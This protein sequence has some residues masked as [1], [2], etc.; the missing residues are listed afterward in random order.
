MNK[1]LTVKEIILLIQKD[2][3]IELRQGFAAA[4]VILFLFTTVFIV[5]KAFAE[6]RQESWNVMFWIIFLFVSLNSILKSF[7][8]EDRNRGLYYYTLFD[9]VKVILSKIIYNFIF[10]LILAFILLLLMSFFVNNPI[11]DFGLFLSGMT[12]S[13]LGISVIFTFV[14]SIS[15]LENNNSTLMAVL[16]MPI[17]LPV[18]LLALKISA[19]AIGIIQDSSVATDFLYLA[20]IDLMMLGLALILFPILW[21]Q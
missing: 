4:G 11:K 6:L 14:S 21:K 13:V 20:A 16:A 17:V 3:A 15:G 7:I 9:P 10:S 12:L 8:Q 2:V 1:Q 5:F 19:E 18:L